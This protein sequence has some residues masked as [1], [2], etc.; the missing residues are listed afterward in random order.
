MPTFIVSAAY[1]SGHTINKPRK[2]ANETESN[3]V[4]FMKTPPIAFLLHRYYPL[5]ESF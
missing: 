4:L 1:A 3:A 2:N 5:R